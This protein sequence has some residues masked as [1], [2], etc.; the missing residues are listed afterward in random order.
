MY[1]VI[2]DVF[3][4]VIFMFLT[5]PNTTNNAQIPGSDFEGLPEY[6]HLL[7]LNNTQ[8]RVCIELPVYDDTAL[9]QSE[10]ATLSVIIDYATNTSVVRPV[11]N[12]RIDDNDSKSQMSAVVSSD[13]IR[14][15]PYSLCIGNATF[16]LKCK[17]LLCMI[18]LHK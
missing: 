3:V 9:E 13:I 17:Y 4:C 1:I 15:N 5:A 11:T 14:S 7:E 16:S 10:W 18:L 6:T 8:R 2:K 12:V